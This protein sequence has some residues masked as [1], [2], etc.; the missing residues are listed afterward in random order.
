MPRPPAERKPK[1]ID[2]RDSKRWYYLRKPV[3]L[4]HR[5][6]R[7]PL[8]EWRTSPEAQWKPE[9][10][11]MQPWLLNKLEN[12]K[13]GDVLIMAPPGLLFQGEVA[14]APAEGPRKPGFLGRIFG[15]F[16]R[17]R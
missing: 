15:I 13:P 1:I 14:P 6:N 4:E 9:R 11:E 10:R 12:A 2:R 5:G 8:A 17:K 7:P 16:R 3:L